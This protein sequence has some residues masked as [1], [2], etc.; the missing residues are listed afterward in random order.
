MAMPA[1]NPAMIMVPMA[2]MTQDVCVGLIRP[3][4]GR[5]SLWRLVLRRAKTPP[6]A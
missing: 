3:P 4:R 2:P 1:M 5:V 6:P